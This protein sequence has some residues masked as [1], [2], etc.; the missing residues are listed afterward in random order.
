MKGRIHSIE[1]FGT[2]DGPGVRFVV[3][4]QGCPMRCLY[5]HNPDTWNL[6]GGTL[7][8][9]EELLSQYRKGKEFYRDGGITASGGEPLMQL[10]FLT[11]LFE[12]AK[13]EGIHT[14]LD[15][16]GSPY[17][18]EEQE[19]YGRLF[20]SLDLVLL[21]IKHSGAREHE[22]LTGKSQ[23]PVLSFAKALDQAKI[24]MIVR[25]VAVPGWTD[26]KE[27][28]RKLGELL[29]KYRNIQE[30]EVL[31]YHTMGVDKYRKLGISY[32][33]EE[34]PPMKKT[35]AEIL[36]NEIRKAAE[37]KQSFQGRCA[38]PECLPSGTAPGSDCHRR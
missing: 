1:T 23:A 8:T 26:T 36:Q 38:Y 37:K 21:D 27:E 31:P 19:A 14:C 34:V 7:Y 4:F 30:I 24:P 35:Q 2:L 20:S 13:K 11:E 15:T 9:A 3:F 16:S 22:M 6:S 18:K 32:R 29:K 33:L 17:R 10:A 28:A 25:H 12:E 5:C